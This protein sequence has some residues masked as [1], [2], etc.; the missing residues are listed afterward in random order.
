MKRMLWMLACA[1]CATIANQLQADDVY[2]VLRNGAKIEGVALK[3]ESDGTLKLQLKA[4]GQS[5][6]FKP[7]TYRYGYVPKPKAVKQ[8][9]EAHEGGKHDAILK[10]AGQIFEHY[11]FLGWGGHIAYI[12]GMSH[13]ANKDYT[14]A[15][16]AFERGRS[17]AAGHEDELAKG[18]VLVMLGLDQFDQVQ[19]VIEKLKKSG[20]DETA[21]FAFN[22][23]GRILAKQGKKKEAVLEFLKTLLLFRPNSVVR[24]R[25]EAREQAVALMKEMNDARW[26]SIQEIN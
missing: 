6:I 8:L 21:A 18:M 2:V 19:A 5:Q 23:Q 17:Y 16:N 4:G 1:F 9:E 26:K 7:G 11:K 15:K 25:N 14:K 22:V 3:A 10:V 13:I 12:E 20:D 24:E